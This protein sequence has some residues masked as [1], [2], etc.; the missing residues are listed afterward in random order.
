METINWLV[1][2]IVTGFVSSGMV[3]LLFLGGHRLERDIRQIAAGLCG[4]LLTIGPGLAAG[5]FG[6]DGDLDFY[7]VYAAS[8]L[9]VSLPAAFVLT[10][11]LERRFRLVAGAFD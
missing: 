2:L 10:R 1:S 5:V 7:V 9:V 6:G 4:P 11:R 3:L 8:H